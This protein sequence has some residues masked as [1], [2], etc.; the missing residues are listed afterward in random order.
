[1]AS[2]LRRQKKPG[3]IAF[4]LLLEMLSSSVRGR[5][6]PTH[7]GILAFPAGGKHCVCGGGGE[8]LP[9]SDA[10]ARCFKQEP[11]HSPSSREAM[12]EST[13]EVAA[14]FRPTKAAAKQVS[15][16]WGEGGGDWEFEVKH[17]EECRSTLGV[18][19]LNNT[20]KNFGGDTFF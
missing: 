1:M 3:R 2:L 19:T 16:C 12:Q 14:S 18:D 5:N 4:W 8:W 6:S 13:R 9:P 17:K 15:E 7:P 10:T 20:T 11:E